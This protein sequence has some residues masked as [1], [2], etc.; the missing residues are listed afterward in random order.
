MRVRCYT[1]FAAIL[2]LAAARL[3]CGGDDS[4]A[5][6]DWPAWRGPTH[7]NHSTDPH[8]PLKWSEDSGI[9]WRVE[10]PGQGH[11]S[12]CISGG[13]IFL[14]SAD[15]AEGVQ[16]IVCFDQRTGAQLWR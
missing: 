14:A 16:F 5:S 2:L 12:P 10:T 8:P 6:A 15:D 7:D 3:A 13:K 1:L 4:G 9:V 11:A